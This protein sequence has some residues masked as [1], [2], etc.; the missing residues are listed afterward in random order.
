MRSFHLN[1]L[2][3]ALTMAKW[4]KQDYKW[5]APKESAGYFEFWNR[6][7]DVLVV[8]VQEGTASVLHEVGGSRKVWNRIKPATVKEAPAPRTLESD[9]QEDR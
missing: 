1:V 9:L 2:E 6:G 7:T 5:T 8:F 3:A 4:R